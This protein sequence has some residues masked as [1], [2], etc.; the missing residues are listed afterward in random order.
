MAEL[1]FQASSQGRRWEES[2]GGGNEGEASWR[3]WQLQDISAS[4]RRLAGG[5]NGELRR[6]T[7]TCLRSLGRRQSQLCI[8][9]HVPWFF[10]K[11]CKTG[12]LLLEVSI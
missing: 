3:S 7:R 4:L 12:L 10:L 9:L 6:W 5:G 2:Q 1:V 11:T 8:K